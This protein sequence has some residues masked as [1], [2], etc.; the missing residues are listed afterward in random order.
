MPVVNGRWVSP[1]KF[2]A[3]LDAEKAAAETPA[4]EEPAPKETKARRSRRSSKKAAEA[5]IADA[6]GATVDVEQTA[7]EETNDETA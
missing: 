3:M 4:P 5:A 7:A 1:T 2:Q 6:T